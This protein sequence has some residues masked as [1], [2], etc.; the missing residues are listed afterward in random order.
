MGPGEDLL[1]IVDVD[2]QIPSRSLDVIVAEEL[3]DVADIDSPLEKM[4][5]PGVPQSMRMEASDSRGKTDVVDS[6]LE[7]ASADAVSLSGKKERG[8]FRVMD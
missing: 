1:K 8:L 7:L 6:G 2:L 5:R 4:G 3:L